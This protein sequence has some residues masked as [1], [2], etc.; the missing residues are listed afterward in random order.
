L[1]ASSFKF[2]F[3]NYYNKDIGY[4]PFERFKLGGTGLVGWNLYGSEV[5]AQRGYDQYTFG[6]GAVNFNKYTL[7]L[8]YPI[9]TNPSATIYGLA[10]TEGGYTYASRREF[11]P[12][13]VAKSAGVGIRVFLPM[14]G[15]LGL[16]YGWP[17]DPYMQ[18]P[19]N[20]GTPRVPPI[21]GQLH[22]TIGANIG[23]L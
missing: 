15:L 19:D 14:F 5:I 13:V 10:F 18:K 23:D 20:R 16:D 11:N 9:S 21:K 4:S 12:F 8:R 17:I 6:S 22:F 2:G 7:E 1:S 3:L